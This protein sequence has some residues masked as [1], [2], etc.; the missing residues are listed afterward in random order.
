MNENNTAYANGDVIELDLKN[1]FWTVIRRY[2]SIIVVMLIVGVLLGGLF[3]LKQYKK[4]T[5][6]ETVAASNQ[7][8]ESE[9]ETYTAKK[10]LLETKIDNLTREI[11]IQSKYQDNAVLLF[12]D[13]YNVY[14]ESVTYYVD[15]GYQI[16][17]ELYFQNPNYTTAIL[18]AYKTILGRVDVNE[19]IRDRSN[20]NLTCEN[21]VSDDEKRVVTIRVDEDNATLII[22]VIG[23][24]KERA[25]TILNTLKE[26]I[27]ENKT[28]IDTVIGQHTITAFSTGSRTTVDLE[29]AGMQSSFN[30]KLTTLTNDVE[31]TAEELEGLTEPKLDVPSRGNIIKTTVKF[32][33]VG[34]FVGLVCMVIVY[35]IRIVT[36]D[37][38]VSA[39]DLVSR[40]H[41]NVLGCCYPLADGRKE[42]RNKLDRIINRKLGFA[43]TSDDGE[44]DR[45][46]AANIRLYAKDDPKLVLLGTAPE[47]DI[48]AVEARLKT[49]LPDVSLEMRGSILERADAVNAL[50][51]KK[52]VVLVE[53]AHISRHSDIAKEIAAV[54]AAG[55]KLAG[56][57]IV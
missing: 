44:N 31:T 36:G 7:K 40:Y 55:S 11:E 39:K 33:V 54:N 38:L 56:V 27:D 49:Q 37:T 8:Y 32:F 41:T 5:S 29:L 52:T 19:I 15:A 14:T 26:V 16:A 10:D 46:I 24:T 17:P 13:P 35:V 30:E 2:R 9:M 25:E 28:T 23:D 6:P 20:P 4:S 22:Q 18:N 45:L 3:G 42:K 47:A 12:I 51:E 1:L 50:M 48:S 21:P 34:L 43:K 53:K 57:I